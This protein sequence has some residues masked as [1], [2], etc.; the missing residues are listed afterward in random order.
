MVIKAT[1]PKAYPAIVSPHRWCF[2]NFPN[3]F[4]IQDLQRHNLSAHIVA[5]SQVAR[6]QP[7][8]RTHLFVQIP[9]AF[10]SAVFRLVRSHSRR[11][12]LLLHPLVSYWALRWQ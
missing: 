7:P 4:H 5:F 11:R 10:T 2:A 3:T 6:L 1:S 8:R 9:T 12:D